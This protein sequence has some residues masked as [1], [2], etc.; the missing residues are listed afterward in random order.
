MPLHMHITISPKL[1]APRENWQT[2]IDI[3]QTPISLS[4]MRRVLAQGWNPRIHPLPF[5][6]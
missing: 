3:S 5:Q 2:G 1:P 4:A 6:L